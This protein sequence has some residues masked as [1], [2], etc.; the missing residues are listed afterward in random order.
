MM[1]RYLLLG[2]VLLVVF[3]L[4]LATFFIARQWEATSLVRMWLECTD[5]DHVQEANDLRVGLQRRPGIYYVSLED[6]DKDSDTAVR[7]GLE[8]LKHAV[9]AA[10]ILD[11]EKW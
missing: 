9:A 3:G 11:L 5:L 2:V 4:I 6:W 7:Q 8:E 10:G 1:R